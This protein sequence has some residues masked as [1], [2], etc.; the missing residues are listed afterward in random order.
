MR[1][2]LHPGPY[3]SRRLKITINTLLERGRARQKGR[4]SDGKLKRGFLGM[5]FPQSP[6]ARSSSGGV[7]GKDS[8]KG[9]SDKGGDFKNSRYSSGGKAARSNPNRARMAWLRYNGLL[10]EKWRVSNYGNI[11]DSY[12]NENYVPMRL[13]NWEGHDLYDCS[14]HTREHACLL[15]YSDDQSTSDKHRNN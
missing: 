9:I 8:D 5:N 10:R 6:R 15:P 11:A 3:I 7:L 12:L 14:C 4:G 2:T 13:N 1:T